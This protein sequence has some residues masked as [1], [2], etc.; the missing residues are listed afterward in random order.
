MSLRTDLKSLAVGFSLC[1]SIFLGS[2][3]STAYG[4]TGSKGGPERNFYEVMD[5]ILGDFEYDLKN[6]D[7]KGLK[8]LSIRNIA[9]S[10]NIPASFKSHL[11]LLITE[12]VL[13][14]AKTRVIQCL[15]CR[16]RKTSLT[17]D[18]ITISNSESNP[19]EISRIAKLSGIE[20]FMDI[21]F[22]YQSSGMVMSMYIV[23]P[24]T[25]S[26]VWSRSYNSETSKV[27]AFRRGVDFSQVDDIR[28]E[29]EYAP[30]IQ[31]RLMLYFVF[32]PN[33]PKTTGLMALGYRMMERYDNRKKEVGFE[34]DYR[35]DASTITNPSGASSGN[36]YRGFGMNLTL[37]FMHSWNFIGE[38]E[39]Y[40]KIR[41]GAF[42]G[43]GGTYASGYLAGL[44]RTGYEW[45][46]GKHSSVSLILGYH[47]QATAF[48]NNTEVGTLSGLEYGLGVSLL[49]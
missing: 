17:G 5:D 31:H 49:F 12:R 22:S 41:G 30:I 1:W 46:L 15:P 32:A 37:L 18:Q 24:D 6:G 33:L 48:L 28:K 2:S 19:T 35:V 4:D 42:V 25:G 23:S 43:L 27:G 26:I 8:D 7:V 11:E 20:H 44:V 47:P 16:S 36:L 3:L 9:T 39:N 38:E 14:A 40:N 34:L 45:R 13:K 10:E 21:A 29:T